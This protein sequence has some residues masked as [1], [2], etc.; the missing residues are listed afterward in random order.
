MSETVE[1]SADENDVARLNEH[2]M[3]PNALFDFWAAICERRI[4]DLL[5]IERG[6]AASQ[7]WSQRGIAADLALFLRDAGITSAEPKDAVPI[8]LQIVKER[9]AADRISA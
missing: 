4:R 3:N 6:T 8:I 1:R 9:A 5:E 2:R 7:Y